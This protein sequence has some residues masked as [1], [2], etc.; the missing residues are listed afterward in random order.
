MWSYMTLAGLLGGMEDRSSLKA[1][2]D[3]PFAN[4]EFC[5]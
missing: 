4:Q 1:L 3:D 2:K 5:D